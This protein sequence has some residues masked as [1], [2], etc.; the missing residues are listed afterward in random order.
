MPSLQTI[1]HGIDLSLYQLREKKQGYLS[2]LGRVA[3]FDGTHL[4][5]QVAR[6]CGIPLKIAGEVQPMFREYFDTQVKPHLDGKFIQY[7]GEVVLQAK[8]ELLGNSLA[9]LFPIEWDEPFGF[10][11]HRYWRCQAERWERLYLME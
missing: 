9:L 5:I 7:V 2:F 11:V 1:H 8:N 10:A 4:A 6:D 3:P